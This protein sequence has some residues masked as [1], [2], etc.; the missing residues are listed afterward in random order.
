M[1]RRNIKER[2]P[3]ESFKIDRIAKK[4]DG[5][6]SMPT[7]TGEIGEII[8]VGTTS[9]RAKIEGYLAHGGVLPHPYQLLIPTNLPNP[10]EMVLQVAMFWLVVLMYQAFPDLVRPTPSI[11]SLIR[12]LPDQNHHR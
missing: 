6:T 4:W 12:I 2:T 3:V 7:W 11:L 10:V 8:A 9:E 1:A 5:T